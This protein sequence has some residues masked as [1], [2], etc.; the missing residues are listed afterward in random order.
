MRTMAIRPALRCLLLAPLAGVLLAQD[1]PKLEGLDVIGAAKAVKA[2]L[3]EPRAK[4]A[5][6]KPWESEIAAL[7]DPRVQVHNQAIAALIRRGAVVVP[8]LKVLSTD[9]DW[10]IRGRVVSV[11]AAIGGDEATAVILD[12]SRDT[13][14]RVGELATLGLG[15]ARG[16]GS[17]PRLAELIRHGDVHMREAAARALGAHG[18][19][20]GLALLCSHARESD[21]LVRRDMRASLQQLAQQPAAVPALARLIAERVGDERLALIDA[22]GVVGDPRLQPVLTALLDGNDARTT[23][24]AARALAANGDSRAVAALCRVAASALALEAREAA[25]GTLR[26]LTGYSAAPGPAW[27]LWWDA[28]HVEIERLHDRD[29]LI[30]ELH[31]PAAAI[32]REAL[33]RFQPADLGPLVDGALGS[34]APWWPA[35]AFAAL[36]ADDAARWTQPLLERIRAAGGVT[37]LGLIV[38]L[39]Q[40]GDAAAADG[41]RQLLDGVPAKSGTPVPASGPERVALQIALERRGIRTR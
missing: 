34:G 1:D 18:D 31:D 25:A 4:A 17:F 7:T 36:Q 41:F 13:D 27:S 21:D 30:A 11:A 5:I 19:A 22:S 9:P 40:L 14:L 37:R 24:A 26:L 6:G 23:T 2:A 12:L 8:D 38:I 10:Q 16:A 35:R 28:H 15:Q 3:S 29:R 33:S 20:A 32:P 39:D